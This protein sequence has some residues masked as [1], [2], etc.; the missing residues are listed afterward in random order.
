MNLQQY[1]NQSTPEKLSGE[2]LAF[3][4]SIAIHFINCGDA[5]KVNVG[6]T[7]SILLNHIDYMTLE[8][9]RNR[10]L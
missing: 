10:H 9:M 1:A 3:M 6:R 2:E 7:M 8:A 5:Q 4:R